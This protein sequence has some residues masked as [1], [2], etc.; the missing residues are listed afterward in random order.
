M[1]LIIVKIKTNL[2]NNNHQIKQFV[3]YQKIQIKKKKLYQTD[4]QVLQ[5]LSN[6]LN[7]KTPQVIGHKKK[8]ACKLDIQIHPQTVS[9]IHL[10]KGK[11]SM[12][13]NKLFQKKV[14]VNLKLVLM[15]TEIE[16]D[17][18]GMKIL[19]VACLVG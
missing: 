17:L 1:Y 19:P 11:F 4:R 3:R 9:D 12:M 6:H 8:T 13:H 7:K 15:I 16:K 18:K 14:K 10:F 2:Q 5:I